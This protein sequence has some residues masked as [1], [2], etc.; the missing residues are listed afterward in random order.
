M[1]FICPVCGYDEM[2]APPRNY[3]ICSCCGTEFGNDDQLQTHDQLRE[4]WIRR[5]ALWFFREPPANW[6]PWRQLI[7]G[8]FS[9]IV[10]ELRGRALFALVLQRYG[11][12]GQGTA[13]NEV[14]S[15]DPPRGDRVINL[16]D[17]VHA[18]TLAFP[19]NAGGSAWSNTIKDPAPELASCQR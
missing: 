11:F 2:D 12:S 13:S 19:S 18:F 15:F 7:L 10:A 8:G 5:G 17:S 4:Q 9:H 3:E 6:D 14:R 16:A 1:N